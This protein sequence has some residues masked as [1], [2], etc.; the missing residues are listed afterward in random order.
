MSKVYLI[1]RPDADIGYDEYDSFIVV[2]RD[3]SEVRNLAK[4]EV[5][6]EG[7]AV[8][9]TAEITLIADK[10]AD[11]QPRTVLGSFNAG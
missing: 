10:C 2:A 5:G 6:D 11:N 3:E 4:V 1:S 9:D 8:W 7:E